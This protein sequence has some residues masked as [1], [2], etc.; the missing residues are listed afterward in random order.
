MHY[1]PP[2]DAGLTVIFAD[3]AL[4][5]I[6]KPAGLLSVPGRGANKQDCL[7]HRA[8]RQFP[9]ALAVHRLDMS[10]S[11]LLL[12]ARGA[13]MHSALSRLFRERLI[14]KRYIAEVEGCPAADSGKI[15]LPLIVDWPNRP[16]QKVD[17]ALGKPSLTR[18]RT[19]ARDAAQQQSRLELE[20]VTGRSHQLRVHLAALGHPIIGDELYGN[21][22]LDSGERLRLHAAA[23]RFVHPLTGEVLRFDS[24]APF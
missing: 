13:A 21:G 19:L 4:L 12:L 3:D 24:E 8:Q 17:F 15:T 2:P 1:Q 20:P 7:L 9:D 6:D 18:F 23:L 16:R 14:D 11:G 10:T 22:S 5:V